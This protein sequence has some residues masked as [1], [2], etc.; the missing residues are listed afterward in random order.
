MFL[1]NTPTLSGAAPAFGLALNSRRDTPFLNNTDVI[2][3]CMCG[4]LGGLPTVLL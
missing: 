3:D 4:S 2:A 1:L